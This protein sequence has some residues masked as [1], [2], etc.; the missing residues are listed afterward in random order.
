[1]RKLFD[2]EAGNVV[3]N[4]SSLWIPQFKAIWDRDKSKSKAKAQREISYVVFMHDFQSPYSAYSDKDKE[5]KILEDY[6]PN[7]PD[8]EPDEVVKAACDKLLELQDSVALRMLR[9]NRKALDLLETYTNNVYEKVANDEIDITDADKIMER[10]LKNAEKSGN[11]VISLNKLE[12]QVQKEQS[13]ASVRGGGV[14][15]DFED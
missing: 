15:G 5:Q 10:L 3:M 12:I 11:L 1:M 4:P 8:W 14:V 2:I 6:F 7:E 9:T 13:E